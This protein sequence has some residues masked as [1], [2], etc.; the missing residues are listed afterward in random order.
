MTV[1]IIFDRSLS[2]SQIVKEDKGSRS[3]NSQTE[4]KYKKSC[5][6]R[7]TKIMDCAKNVPTSL[8]EDGRRS[9]LDKSRLA[10]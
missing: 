6:L 8:L 5:N 1:P 4:I 2:E 3:G 9:L 10:R 7:R